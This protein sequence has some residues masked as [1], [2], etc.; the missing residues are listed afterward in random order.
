MNSERSDMST[1]IKTEC[2]E[3]IFGLELLGLSWKKRRKLVGYFA[4]PHDAADPT[5]TYEEFDARILHNLTAEEWRDGGSV[6]QANSFLRS[7]E[8]KRVRTIAH[9]VY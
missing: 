2:C 9:V 3:V 4:P 7:E 8:M 6:Y 1:R 5:G